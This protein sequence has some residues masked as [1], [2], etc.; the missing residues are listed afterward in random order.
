[1]RLGEIAHRAN[2]RRAN[3]ERELEMADEFIGPHL[4][5]VARALYSPY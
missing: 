5:D 1:V 4:S 2:E 3:L